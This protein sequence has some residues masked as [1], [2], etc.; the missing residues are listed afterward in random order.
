MYRVFHNENDGGIF[1]D[2]EKRAK[3]FC[4]RHKG[5]KYVLVGGV[6]SSSVYT[7]NSCGIPFTREEALA[8]INGKGYHGHHGCRFCP[9]NRGH[10]QVASRI[11]GPC[12]HQV[13]CVALNCEED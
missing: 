11:A 13:C 12:G 2:T 6:I 9:H 10:E 5:F 1:F 4:A 8:F 7:T 3:A